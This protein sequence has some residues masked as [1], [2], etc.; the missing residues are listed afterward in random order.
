M[1]SCNAL[2]LFFSA[3][4][5]FLARLAAGDYGSWQSAHATF[6]GEADASGTMGELS[7][8]LHC[9]KQKHHYLWTVVPN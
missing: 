9:S 7:S 2:L 8:L 3:A 4:F 1:A 5:C 6:Y